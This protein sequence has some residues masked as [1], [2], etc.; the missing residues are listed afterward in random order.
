M[1]SSKIAF[2][3]W[4]L[5]AGAGASARNVL[6]GLR[7]AE[8]NRIRIA[9]RTARLHPGIY[10]LVTL[11]DES[12]GAVLPLRPSPGHPRSKDPAFRDACV[13][14]YELARIILEE[15][16]LPMLRFELEEELAVFGPSIGLP[17]A[18]SFLAFYAPSRMPVRAVIATGALSIDGGGRVGEVGQIEA[19]QAIAKQERGAP[20]DP[21]PLLLLPSDV[22]TL[23]EAR[24]RVFGAP[25]IRLDVTQSPLDVIIYRARTLALAPES[26]AL[27]ES[28]DRSAL[29]PADRARVMFDLGT[30]HRNIGENRRAWALHEEARQLL[31]TERHVIG[32][33]ASE[34]Y[35]LECWATELDQYRLD[36]ATRALRER[37][38]RPFLKLRNELRCRGMF[39]QGLAM[40]GDFAEAVAVREENLKLHE[41]SDA[42][43]KIRPVTLCLLVLDAGLAR[44]EAKFDRYGVALA[45][46]T[47]PGD[48]HQWRYNAA[49]IVRGLVALGRYESAVRFLC[50]E[51]GAERVFDCRA[52]QTLVLAANGTSTTITAPEISALRA[53]VRALRRM[54]RADEGARV[55]A[56]S[57]SAAGEPPELFGWMA[58]LLGL[59]VAL[60]HQDAGKYEEAET[61]MRE[62]RALLE[63]SH[64][65]ATTFHARLRSADPE[66][67]LDRVWY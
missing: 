60:A 61:R 36:E 34:R 35:D 41:R 27:L 19:K 18:L 29:R 7:G 55:G 52:P 15:R 33:E 5:G 44:D 64:R 67:E 23:E 20:G 57:V 13:T 22:S 51:E 46:A 62:A 59:E 17:A 43:G 58:G 31:V 21:E 66:N 63:R 6:G 32:E 42:L 24:K 56:R 37:L 54:G 26:I 49:A 1:N 4:L 12:V 65:E 48:E 9:S 28:V 14:A 30:F 53:L 8:A 39:A 50:D 11:P 45:A 40:R 47:K 25:P 16:S 2:A 38:S 3:R 10:C